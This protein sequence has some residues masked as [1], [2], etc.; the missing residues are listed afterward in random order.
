MIWDL[1]CW[2]AA[3]PE[4]EYDSLE[5]EPLGSLDDSEMN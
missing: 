4:L 5:R 3:E 1:L 2:Q